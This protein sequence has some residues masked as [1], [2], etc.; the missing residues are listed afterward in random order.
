M[1][2]QFANWVDVLQTQASLRPDKVAFTFLADGERTTVPLTY[3]QLDQQAR[4]IAA[5]LAIHAAP[6]A[7]VLLL[8]PPGLE[9]IAGFFSCLYAGMVG[10]PATPPLTQK[11]MERVDV[12]LR[13][14]DASAVLTTAA[15]RSRLL[16]RSDRGSPLNALPCLATDALELAPAQH[17]ARPLPRRRPLLSCNTPPAQ[18][19]IPKE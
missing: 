8:Y 4:R 7:R 15:V 3:Q 9:F 13:D 5:E 18:P 11:A 14:S 16:R 2:G 10:V 19:G 6:G 12:L 17:G 1:L